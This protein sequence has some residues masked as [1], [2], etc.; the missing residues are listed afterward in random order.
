[1]IP[2]SRGNARQSTAN[3]MN[4]GGIAGFCHTPDEMSRAHDKVMLVFAKALPCSLT[5]G[6]SEACCNPI[7]V[8]PVRTD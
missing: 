7:L 1:M 8:S 5:C 2:A 6:T 3:T 4:S